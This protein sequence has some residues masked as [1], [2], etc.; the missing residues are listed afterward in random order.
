MNLTT[1]ILLTKLVIKP[2]RPRWETLGQRNFVRMG[3][4]HEH[5]GREIQKHQT[6]KVFHH[7]I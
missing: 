5:A 1:L 7:A 2:Q 4:V 3:I 6:Q